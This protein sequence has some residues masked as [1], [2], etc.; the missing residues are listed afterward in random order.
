MDAPTVVWEAWREQVKHLFPS[1]HGH[2]QKAL[3]WMVLG[4]VLSGNAVLQRM[5]DR[6]VWDQSGQDAQQ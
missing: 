4:V 3:A 6:L 1:L 2:Q 5:R